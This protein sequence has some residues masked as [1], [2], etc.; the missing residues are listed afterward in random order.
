MFLVICGFYFYFFLSY[1][2]VT[3]DDMWWKSYSYLRK[4]YFDY[5]VTVVEEMFSPPD[6]V[7]FLSQFANGQGLER[8]ILS[9][10]DLLRIKK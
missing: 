2:E 9:S 4:F 1:T 7:I 8:R 5:C 6:T 3:V 10:R